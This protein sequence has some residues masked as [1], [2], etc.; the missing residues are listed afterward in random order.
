MATISDW[1][2]KFVPWVTARL[3]LHDWPLKADDPYWRELEANFAKRGYDKEIVKLAVQ[4]MMDDPPR[5]IVQFLPRLHDEYRKAQ[6][7]LLQEEASRRV[8]APELEEAKAISKDCPECM[9]NGMVQRFAK[10]PLMG[11]PFN[12]QLWRPWLACRCPF[13]RALL[14]INK[15]FDDLQSL[16]HL[17]T[18]G[19]EFPLWF[20]KPTPRLPVGEGVIYLN[21]DDSPPPRTLDELKRAV[22]RQTRMPRK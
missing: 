7:R 10:F 3:R 4:A 21:L 8:V 6:G 15:G 11:P 1:F 22:A 19:L 14:T 17:W 16:P 2:D 18:P 5:G 9:G 20:D 13:G 12:E